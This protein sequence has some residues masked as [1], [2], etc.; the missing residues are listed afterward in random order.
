MNDFSY[1]MDE[2]HAFD[3]AL[4]TGIEGFSVERDGIT[5][6]VTPKHLNGYG[7]IVVEMTC[8]EFPDYI[9]TAAVWNW[10]WRIVGSDMYNWHQLNVRFTV[11]KEMKMPQT[12]KP[13]VDA[14]NLDG[15]IFA[16]AGAVRKA[17]NRARRYGDSVSV[18]GLVTTS[19]SYEEALSRLA[20]LVEF[21]FGGGDDEEETEDGE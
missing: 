2:Y 20:D 7:M 19:K 18:V 5:V 14:R 21:D 16:V 12:A 13:V 11:L 17:L 1:T 6:D 4:P 10:D 15:N 8:Q 9:H 3:K